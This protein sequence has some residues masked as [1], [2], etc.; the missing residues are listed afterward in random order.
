MGAFAVKDRASLRATD[1][2][3]AQ[4]AECLPADP[5]TPISC[6]MVRYYGYYSNVTRGKMKRMTLIS[7]YSIR[8]RP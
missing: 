5:A 8:R 6:Q 7:F 3:A 1:L 2:E 4:A